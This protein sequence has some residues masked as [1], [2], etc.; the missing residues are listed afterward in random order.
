MIQ[1]R[2]SREIVYC[3]I[4]TNMADPRH[5]AEG[6]LQTDMGSGNIATWYESGIADGGV[7]NFP[8]ILT[9]VE[10]VCCNMNMNIP[11]IFSNNTL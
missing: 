10:A 5:G 2:F 4:L 11:V 9:N 7:T 1:R 6:E 8:G 3:D